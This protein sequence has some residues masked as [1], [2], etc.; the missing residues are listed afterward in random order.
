[1]FRKFM[2]NI[3]SRRDRVRTEIQFQASLLSCGDQT[4]CGSLV[5]VDIHIDTLLSGFR[6][7]RISVGNR[8]VRVVSVIVA[9]L[10]HLDV[11][12]SH[13]WFLSEL[14]LQHVSGD[15]GV[16]VEQPADQTEG[17]HVTA[18]QDSLR[19]HA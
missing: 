1:M 3:C 2:K 9:R 10:D 14:L 13:T 17:E 11:R 5:T 8:R 16:A 7:H 18:L 12:L 6:L 15:V 4:V 19:I